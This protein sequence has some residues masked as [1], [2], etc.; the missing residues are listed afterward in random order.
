MQ[1]QDTKEKEKTQRHNEKLE[2]TLNPKMRYEDKDYTKSLQGNVEK[3]NEAVKIATQRKTIN[4]GE[5]RKNVDKTTGL[6]KQKMWLGV[7]DLSE[8]DSESDEETEQIKHEETEESINIM[9]TSDN[10]KELKKETCSNHEVEKPIENTTDTTVE[11]VTQEKKTQELH[12]REVQ[13]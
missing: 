1:D 10:D 7:N 13:V 8:E 4:T 2:R 9:K 11:K 6:K 5:K 3:V 12:K